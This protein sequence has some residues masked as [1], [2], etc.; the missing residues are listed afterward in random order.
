MEEK[1]G[2]YSREFLVGVCR[3]ILQ[4]LTIFQTK[5]CRYLNRLQTWPIRNTV[6]TTYIRTAAKIYF[7]FAYFSFF[8]NH[9]ELK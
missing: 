5:K 2:G 3:P 8:L 4:I 1:P 7:E 9:L 6:V